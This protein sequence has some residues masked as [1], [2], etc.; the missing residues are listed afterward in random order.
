MVSSLT[1]NDFLPLLG[2]HFNI[3][4][5]ISL[6]LTPMWR[7]EPGGLQ[8][9]NVNLLSMDANRCH[10][11]WKMQIIYKNA[12]RLKTDTLLF[13]KKHFILWIEFWGI[14]V[15]NG[16]GKKF[17]IRHG[18][19]FLTHHRSCIHSPFAWEQGILS[20]WDK[21]NTRSLLSLDTL[22]TWPLKCCQTQL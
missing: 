16:K 18:I 13:I 14:C 11:L 7:S 19:K 20:A 5:H 17:Q 21:K 9:S 6:Y 2:L 1:L 12:V 22:T 4:F 3:P 15:S 10:I 8:T